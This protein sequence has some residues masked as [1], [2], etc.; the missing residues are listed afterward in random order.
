M[1][2]IRAAAHAFPRNVVSQETVKDMVCGVFS[3]AFKDLDRLLHGESG[4]QRE[5]H[6]PRW[7]LRWP[8]Q[9]LRL[10]V[11]YLLMRPAVFLLGWPQVVG[12]ENLRGV[13]GPV[14]V[15]SNHV[16]DSSSIYAVRYRN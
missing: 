7:T 16:G 4:G 15:I 6:Y 13:T 2:R 12:L 10:A 8:A 9:W 3:D 14:L 5:F 1:P 11:H